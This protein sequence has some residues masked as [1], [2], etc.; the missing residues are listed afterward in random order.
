MQKEK[1]FSNSES[2]S[3]EHSIWTLD[4]KCGVRPV[5]CEVLEGRKC[6]AENQA[7]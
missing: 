4:R 7:A 6:W 2:C 5:R 3:Q 1:L